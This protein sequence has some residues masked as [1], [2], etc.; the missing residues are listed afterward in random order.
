MAEPR[1][2]RRR[3]AA[4]TAIVAAP[5]YVM[6]G[7]TH[8]C[9][10]GHMHH[11]PYPSWQYAADATWLVG[12]IV[13]VVLAVGSN[14]PARRAFLTLAVLLPISRL[15]LGSGGGILFLLELPVLLAL[16]VLA[17]LGLFRSGTDWT[18]VSVEE[19]AQR[20]RRLARRTGIAGAVLA[21]V[22]LLIWLVSWGHRRVRE[23]S[24]E[25]IH[26]A[27]TDLPFEKRVTLREGHAATLALPNGKDVAFWCKRGS[28][29]FDG[30]G[31]GL[32]WGER[33]FA[34]PKLKY[35]RR[36]DG[37]EG[38]V[39]WD[40]YI[41]QGTVSSWSG[42]YG[43]QYELFV[44]KYRVTLREEEPSRGSLPVKVKV[45]LA[46]EKEQVPREAERAYFLKTLTS[47]DPSKRIDAM[48]E[49]R[50]M[51]SLRSIHAGDPDEIIAA[52]RSLVEDPD[53]RVKAKA[54]ESLFALGD[55]DTLWVLVAPEPAGDWRN[56]EGGEKLAHACRQRPSAKINKH[57]L[58]FFES[59]D[60]ALFEFAASFFSFVEYAP[61]KEHILEALKHPSPAVR[62]NA[63]GSLRSYCEGAEI[64][65]HLR[66]MLNDPDKDVLAA[67]LLEA[68]D[69]TENLGV[70]AIIRLLEHE[71]AYV[72]E[73]ACGTLCR[74]SGPEVGPALMGG[75]R[76]RSPGVRAR[77]AVALGQIRAPGAYEKLVELLGDSVPE[78]RASAVNGFRWLG[79]KRSIPVV[80]ELLKTER[81]RA[82]RD[83]ASR[84]LQELSR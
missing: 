7:F 79:D 52:I 32:S 5:L 16:V 38:S 44:D 28:R 36:P 10:A 21:G 83:M 48:N 73:M 29:V 76:D 63:V 56:R 64:V 75:T 54:K 31:L 12:F 59:E 84:T 23:A 74:S 67:V 15:L 1:S 8:V 40:S 18:K 49:L 39:G 53:A 50:Q 37:S 66:P 6:C 51:V 30:P 22:L 13:A 26:V 55:E 19:R 20:R 45:R 34:A 17:I 47:E 80:K 35:G 43:S 60:P 78:V 68:G 11:P 41:R 33:P 69:W 4:A 25:R 46:T 57:V 77:A 9:M 42:S 3:I 65:R 27:G 2:L 82:V 72:R 70:K 61:A 62:E 14:L 24:A 58:T 81:D 71:D